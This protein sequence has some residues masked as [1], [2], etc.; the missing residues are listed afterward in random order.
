M[1]ISSARRVHGRAAHTEREV[2]DVVRFARR[3][4]LSVHPPVTRDITHS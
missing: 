3:E 4:R 1:A 2:V